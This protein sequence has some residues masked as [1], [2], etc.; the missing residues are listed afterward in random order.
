[1]SCD[2]IWSVH[3]SD[4]GQWVATEETKASARRTAKARGWL[5]NYRSGAGMLLDYCPDCRKAREL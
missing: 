3:C 5:V 1:M 2:P 4:C